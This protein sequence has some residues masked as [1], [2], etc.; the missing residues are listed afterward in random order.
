MTRPECE[1]QGIIVFDD[2]D[3]SDTFRACRKCGLYVT[4]DTKCQTCG[5]ECG[6]ELCP[7]CSRSAALRANEVARRLLGCGEEQCEHEAKR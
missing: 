1:C 7:K 3:D 2:D 6:R 5:I 4:E